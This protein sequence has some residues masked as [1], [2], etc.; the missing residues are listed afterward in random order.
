MTVILDTKAVG[1]SECRNCGGEIKGDIPTFTG[2]RTDPNMKDPLDPGF[3]C[4]V[5]ICWRCIMEM[6]R[7]ARVYMGDS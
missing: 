3:P 4:I 6:S 7:A 2:L 5:V 1:R